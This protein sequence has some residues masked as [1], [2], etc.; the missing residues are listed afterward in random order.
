M[1]SSFLVFHDSISGGHVG[2]CRILIRL[3]PKCLDPK[4]QADSFIRLEVIDKR[5]PV[6]LAQL[7]GHVT[8]LRVSV[9]KT[10][11]GLKASFL[12]TN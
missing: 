8:G 2:L 6:T 4:S 7:A 10:Q 11:R 9:L 1:I 5:N 3:D 12:E